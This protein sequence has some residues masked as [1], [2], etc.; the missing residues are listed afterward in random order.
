MR[1]SDIVTFITRG[2]T[3]G[4]DDM[5]N[6]V[7]S[8]DITKEVICNVNNATDDQAFSGYSIGF[9]KIETGGIKIRMRI[10]EFDTAW[11]QAIYKGNKYSLQSVELGN[12]LITIHGVRVYG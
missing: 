10:S 5:G 1:M 7:T 6:I 3:S 2:T 9:G 12:D 4:Y 11:T 8:P